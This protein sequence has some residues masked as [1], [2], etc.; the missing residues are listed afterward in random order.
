M[1]SS[2]L[3]AGVLALSALACAPADD[4]DGVDC[5]PADPPLTIVVA[6]VPDATVTV[7]RQDGVPVE[8]TCGT[9]GAD[10]SCESTTRE[11]AQPGVYLVHA[12]AT[13]YEPADLEV[14]VEA[15]PPGGCCNPGYVA[16]TVT[17]DLVAR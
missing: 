4:C 16:E 1:R 9:L 6:G 14:T 3:V 8:T 11:A 15:T 5:G 2:W 10:T 17:I 7:T 12:E 13:G